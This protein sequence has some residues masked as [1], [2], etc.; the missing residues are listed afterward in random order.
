MGMTESDSPRHL[1]MI[2]AVDDLKRRSTIIHR[3]NSFCEAGTK[4]SVICPLQRAGDEEELAQILNR[5]ATVYTVPVHFPAAECYDLA[6][7]LGHSLSNV[8]QRLY[9]TWFAIGKDRRLDEPIKKFP[10]G[11]RQ[12]LQ[13]VADIWYKEVSK[14]MQ[15]GLANHRYWNI[16]FAQQIPPAMYKKYKDVIQLNCFDY[17]FFFQALIISK[18][19]EPIDAIFCYDLCTLPVGCL[20][21]E[22]LGITLI[23]YSHSNMETSSVRGD[24]ASKAVAENNQKWMYELCDRFI[25]VNDA[26]AEYYFSLCPSLKS[27]EIDT[28]FPRSAAYWE[29]RYS[30]GGTSGTGSYGQ[31]ADFKAE[32]LNRF[33]KE[34]EIE[35]VIEFGCGDGNQLQSATYPCYIGLDV[36]RYALGLCRQRFHDDPTKRFFLYD[37]NCFMDKEGIFRADLALS[38][39]VIYHL[40]ENDVY[41]AYMRDLVQSATRFIIIYSPDFDAHSAQATPIMHLAPACR[42]RNFSRWI[43]EHAPDWVLEQKIENRFPYIPGVRS[44]GSLSDFYIYSKRASCTASASCGSILNAPNVHHGAIS[45]DFA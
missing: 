23:Y 27:L 12:M 37:S 25:T 21:K 7:L 9:S 29:Q 10:W 42:F 3:I 26:Y 8:W 1:S 30:E 38:L 20:V 34:R 43:S 28:A 15:D 2:A 6:A 44:H 14:I 31:Y 18:S 17:F 39:D 24:S 19:I 22:L 4:V 36:S 41:E 16:Y 5:D 32:V 33:V 13:A 45:G 11:L 35:S 40:I